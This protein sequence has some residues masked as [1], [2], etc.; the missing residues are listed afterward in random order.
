MESLSHDCMRRL[1][2]AI[3]KK[4]WDKKYRTKQRPIFFVP[5]FLSNYSSGSRQHRDDSRGAARAAFDLH[6]ERDDRGAFCGQAIEVRDVLQTVD[7]RAV[8]N[9]VRYEIFRRA[10]I[11]AC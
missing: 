9:L 8:Q 5:H 4:M 10:V 1:Q 2:P 3:D 11:H 6:R 7:V